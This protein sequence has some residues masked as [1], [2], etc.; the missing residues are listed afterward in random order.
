MFQF[1]F[2]ISSRPCHLGGWLQLG[3]ALV[4]VAAFGCHLPRG[5][6]ATVQD[7]AKA[8]LFAALGVYRYKDFP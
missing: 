7:E 2:W 3:D 1:R 8:S 5:V 6:H 4:G